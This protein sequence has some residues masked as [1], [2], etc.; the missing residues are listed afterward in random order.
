MKCTINAIFLPFH[1]GLSLW[2]KGS[3]PCLLAVQFHALGHVIPERCD[4]VSLNNWWKSWCE[5]EI[6]VTCWGRAVATQRGRRS[7]GRT[8]RSP[9]PATLG[10]L[11]RRRAAPAEG[12][13]PSILKPIK[14]SGM[15]KKTRWFGIHWSWHRWKLVSYCFSVRSFPSR[16]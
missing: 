11:R 16:F 5:Q 2:S 14:L 9:R 15:N 4:K 8:R 6:V 3:T 12:R 13:R 10:T 7:H 1:H